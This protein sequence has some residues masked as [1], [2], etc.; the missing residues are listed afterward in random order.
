[1]NTPITVQYKINVPIEK[2]WTA[3]TDKNEMKSWYFDIQDFEPELGN[4]FNFYEP[5]GENKYH[6]QGEILEIISHKKLKH[7]WAYPDFSDQKTT[8]IWE[9]QSEDN[10]TLVT[11]THEG[12]EN[13][14][15][16]GEGFSRKNFTGGW[17]AIL[18]QSLK[19]YLE[20]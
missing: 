7:T 12:I 18:G 5:G 17:N 13:F 1:M 19:E 16:L 11:L 3:L 6:H 8:V 15:D 10:G 2:V 9:L 20:K 14:K 4:V